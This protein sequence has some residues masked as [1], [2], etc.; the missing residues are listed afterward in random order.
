MCSSVE[1]PQ[2]LSLLLS[3]TPSVEETCDSCKDA[4]SKMAAALADNTKQ[5]Q[6]R[7]RR[8]ARGWRVVHARA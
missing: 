8:P 5:S 3:S 4:A 7:P 6:V 1:L 2:L